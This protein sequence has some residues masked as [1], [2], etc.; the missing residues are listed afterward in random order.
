MFRRAVLIC[1]L[2][3]GLISLGGEI[4]RLRFVPILAAAAYG[5]GVSMHLVETAYPLADVLTRVPF[6]GGDPALAIAF[7]IVFAITAAVQVIAAFMEH[8]Q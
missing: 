6:F 7:A 3:G 8:N 4:L 5:L 1:M 2:G